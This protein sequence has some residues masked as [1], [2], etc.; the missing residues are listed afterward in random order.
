[1]LLPSCSLPFRVSGGH[2][3][4]L[5]TVSA[6]SPS[7]SCAHSPL[8][9]TKSRLSASKEVTGAATSILPCLLRSHGSYLLCSSMFRTSTGTSHHQGALHRP[10][11]LARASFKL[12]L[13]C[14]SAPLTPSTRAPG[15]ASSPVPALYLASFFSLLLHPTFQRHSS[16]CPPPKKDHQPGA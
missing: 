4:H 8:S 3:K 10:P 5:L 11:H 16:P 9:G 2:C 7:G 15:G 12:G 14:S 1:M 13:T 6:A